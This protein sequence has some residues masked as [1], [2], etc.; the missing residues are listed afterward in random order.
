MLKVL[1]IFIDGIGLRAP[2][3][4]NPMHAGVCPA[5]CEL[6]ER[7]SVPID[8]CLGVKGLPQSATGQATMFTGV[9]ASQHMGRHC[10]GF[11]GPTLKRVIQNN[12]LF[13][14]LTRKNVRCRFADAYMIDNVDEL[15]PRRFKS[16]TTVMVLTEPKTISTQSDLLENQAV[17]HDITRSYLREKGHDVP[18]VE[19]HQAAEHL[20][21]V[22]RA[23]D[24]TLFEFFLTDIAGHSRSYDK[25]CNT[26]SMLD[27]FIA[28]VA[29]LCKATNMLL[30]ITSD[31]GNIEDMGTHGHTRNQIPLMAVG[32]KSEKILTNA[33]SLI[34]VTPRIL[35]LF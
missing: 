22:A 21:Q 6:I 31:H 26:L 10:E 27:K 3:A 7:H 34:Q 23:N 4:D 2:A 16:V 9:N 11:P 19:P 32:P 12:N 1:Y 14:E 15:V 8:A 24:F 13:M 30:V 28:V 20:I 25:A 18:L 17:S 5:L 29:A 33:S 35:R